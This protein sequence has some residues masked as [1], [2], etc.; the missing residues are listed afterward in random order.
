MPYTLDTRANLPPNVQKM[1]AAGQKRWVGIWNSTYQ[2][3]M[4][5]PEGRDSGRCETKAFQ[6]ANG[7][8]KNSGKAAHSMAET[9]F[10]KLSR[11]E[12]LAMIAAK[13]S[14]KKVKKDK[15]GKLASQDNNKK[16]G[17]GKAE[18][19]MAERTLA[20]FA[21]DVAETKFVGKKDRSNAIVKDGLVYRDGLIFRSGNYPDKNFS[22]S[23]E[24]LKQ[25]AEKFS[26]PLDI[27]LEHVPTPLD[28]K[29]G[30]LVAVEANADGTELHGVVAIPKWLDSILPK[31]KVSAS[32]DR[33]KKTL[34][35]LALVRHPRVSDAALMAA[36][37]VEEVLL[38]N[39]T[40]D[41]L[42]ELA[43]NM[44]GYDGMVATGGKEGQSAHDV[45]EHNDDTPDGKVG[46]RSVHGLKV[47]KTFQKI[48]DITAGRGAICTSEPQPGT[49]NQYGIVRYSTA[50]EIAALQGM[51]DMTL[52]NGASCSLTNLYGDTARTMPG[53]WTWEYPGLKSDGRQSIAGETKPS[54]FN[55]A[56]DTLKGG[57]NMGSKLDRIMAALEDDEDTEDKASVK[58]DSKSDFTEELRSADEERAR[59]REENRK[60]RLQGITERAVNFADKLVAEGKVVPAEKDPIVSMH[61]QLGT[62]DG[63]VGTASFSDGS[64]RVSM[65]EAIFAARPK[66]M[67]DAEAAP[68]AINELV[69][70]ANSMRTVT[71]KPGD[72]PMTSDR[73]R[74]LLRLDPI[75][76]QVLK[77]EDARSNGNGR[78]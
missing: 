73:R 75:G 60:L 23:P 7:V 18:H 46:S 24:E 61:V 6:I 34:A 63:F 15:N 66:H 58:T 69:A 8:I 22:L 55:A 76:Q 78:H 41:D 53:R 29:M 64:S 67:L 14:G 28:G 47:L 68:K 10:K 50:G 3:C 30:Q 11:Q 31:H 37:A 44:D 54:H 59:L 65:F 4:Q 72:G 51:H 70:F 71:T 25:A 19:S 5:G 17:A 26:N 38:G 20:D 9:D 49:R 39:A 74:E 48:H 1:S 35:G 21:T 42:V 45:A 13:K 27:D 62:D 2:S 40:E 56:D 52:T 57:K 33:A 12:F 43:A 36:F 32:W 77:D 16:V